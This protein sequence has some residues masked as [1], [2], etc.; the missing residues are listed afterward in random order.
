MFWRSRVVVQVVNL[1]VA[2][3]LEH[4][5]IFGPVGRIQR[6]VFWYTGGGCRSYAV[7]V[8]HGETVVTMAPYCGPNNSILM[9]HMN[10]HRSTTL[11]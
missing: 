9:I 6:S 11:A 4:V 3:V 8:C 1:D 7:S 10:R 5:N 2:L